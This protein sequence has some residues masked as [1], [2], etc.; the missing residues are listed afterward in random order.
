MYEGG[1]IDIYIL[2][3]AIRRANDTVKIKTKN[4]IIVGKIN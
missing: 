4:V 1:L 3:G 2:L